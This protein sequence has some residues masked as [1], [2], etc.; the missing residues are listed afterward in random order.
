MLLCTTYGIYLKSCNQALELYTVLD[1]RRRKNMRMAA[2]V[3]FKEILW[4][5]VNLTFEGNQTIKRRCGCN[6]FRLSTQFCSSEEITSIGED[7]ESIVL[8]CEI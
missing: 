2:V 5:V 8:K 4:G 1:T 3:N 6:K 7:R